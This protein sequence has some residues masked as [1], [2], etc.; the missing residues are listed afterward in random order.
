[1]AAV[2]RPVTG[3]SGSV[4]GDLDRYGVV[5][6]PDRHLG[7]GR[8]GVLEDVGQRL[9]DDPVHRHGRG[10]GDRGEVPVNGQ[11]HRQAG[12]PD[13]GSQR[14]QFAGARLRGEPGPLVWVA[15]DMQQAASLLQCLPRAVL[16]LL[17]DP[18][19]WLSRRTGAA[20]L[21]HDHAQ[22]MGD[23]VVQFPGDPCPLSRGGLLGL[24]LRGG[25]PRGQRDGP[26]AGVDEHARQPEC[27]Q[28]EERQC[29]GHRAA[30]PTQGEGQRQLAPVADRGH[31]RGGEDQR[32][33]R[34]AEAGVRAQRV[35]GSEQ[36][37]RERQTLHQ[38][39]GEQAQ[40]SYASPDRQPHQQRRA[41]AQR[42]RPAQQQGQ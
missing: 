34:A 19:G 33:G 15:Q 17:Q 38:V 36:H 23:D 5:L 32:G 20:C 7:A 2:R 28:L 26:P 11:S 13:A 24:T 29:H 12:G 25:A 6:A 30:L 39:V 14:V 16:D 37:E 1:V 21:Q 35:G 22:V 3:L 40:Q 9:L 8:A 41:A 18:A 42:Q 27:Q 10:R 31:D 4:V